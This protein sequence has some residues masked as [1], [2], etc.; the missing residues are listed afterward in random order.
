MGVIYLTQEGYDQLKAE[1]K[2]YESVERNRISQ[3]IADAR[4]KGDLSE[5]AEYDAAKEDQSFMETK[6]AQLKNTY[7]NARIVHPSQI[8]TDVVQILNKVRVLNTTRNKESVYSI[9]SAKEANILEGKIS[10][11]TPIAKAL[12]GHKV[13]DE[14][15]AHVPA[16]VI[17]F[18][19]LE[20]FL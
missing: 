12:M 19:I 1:I 13:G 16:G 7:A 2:F 17:T 4:D 20:I 15:K 6:L 8:K 3:Q 18:K 9:V 14:V 11:E 5:N 10:T